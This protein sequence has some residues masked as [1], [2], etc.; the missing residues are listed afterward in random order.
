MAYLPF[1]ISCLLV[2]VGLSLI[3]G[4]FVY[5]RRA[6][7][8]A[9]TGVGPEFVPAIPVFWVG[10]TVLGSFLIL[11]G[12]GGTVADHYGVFGIS[13]KQDV[14]VGT[15]A[16][17]ESS[18][19][20]RVK[21]DAGQIENLKPQDEFVILLRAKIGQDKPNVDTA[22]ESFRGMNGRHCVLHGDWVSIPAQKE[23]WVKTSECDQP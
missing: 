8:K 20:A 10:S 22:Y 5:L 11:T 9:P 6:K 4:R 2:L 23:F 16:N 7:Q 3:V 19:I 12:V 18:Q 14:L 17:A 21:P 13:R 1:L 15:I